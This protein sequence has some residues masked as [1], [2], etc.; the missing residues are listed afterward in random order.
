VAY[1]IIIM[2]SSTLCSSLNDDMSASSDVCHEKLLLS[3]ASAALKN[4]NKQLSDAD[5]DLSALPAY[6]HSCNARQVERRHSS[7]PR[8]QK[9]IPRSCVL[10][11]KS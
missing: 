8:M 11:A 6:S 9:A 4:K 1:A 10:I 2:T 3:L 7:V 5:V